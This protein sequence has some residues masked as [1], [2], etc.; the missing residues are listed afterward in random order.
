MK[1]VSKFGSV[2][3]FVAGAVAT[4]AMVGCS[5]P[6]DAPPSGTTT[7]P[8]HLVLAYDGTTVVSDQAADGSIRVEPKNANGEA[9]MALVVR[10]DRVEVEPLG[11]RTLAPWSGTIPA[12]AGKQEL[13]D[14]SYRAY[15]YS[16]HVE[17]PKLPISD[18]GGVKPQMQ[19]AGT[20][21]Q[22]CIAAGGT[23]FE[24]AYWLYCRRHWCLGW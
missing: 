22:M 3:A 17:A 7:A 10:G 14:W 2:F 8:Q 4:V 18:Q 1:M 6:V 16:Q 13:E 5:A 24:C 15:A 11:D 23:A 12:D 21:G 20:D 19:S 9:L